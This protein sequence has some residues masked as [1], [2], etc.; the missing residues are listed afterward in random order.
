MF[1]EQR[2]YHLDGV[3][4]AWDQFIRAADQ[5]GE[6]QLPGLKT[7]SEAAQIL[8]KHSHLVEVVTLMES[9]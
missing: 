3:E 8:R 2:V 6:W 5:Y 7:T 9:P 4:V 1:C